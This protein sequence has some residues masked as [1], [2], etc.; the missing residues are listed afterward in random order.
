MCVGRSG[1]CS[2]QGKDVNRRSGRRKQD[3][4]VGGRTRRVEVKAGGG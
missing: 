2:Q 1:G 3:E 4:K